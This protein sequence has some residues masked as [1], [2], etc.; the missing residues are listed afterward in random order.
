MKGQAA[1]LGTKEQVWLFPEGE[2]TCTGL[3]EKRE[4]HK[5]GG[6]VQKFADPGAV[7]RGIKENYE[8]LKGYKIVPLTDVKTKNVL[9]LLCS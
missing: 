2:C 5:R 3:Q 8:C 6:G 4:W 1:A 9:T 7:L